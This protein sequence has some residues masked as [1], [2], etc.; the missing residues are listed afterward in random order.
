MNSQFYY[1]RLFKKNK[2][3]AQK[4]M[5]KCSSSHNQ[6]K[7]ILEHINMFFNI[8]MVKL[9][10]LKSHCWEQSGRQTPS[11]KVGGRS[12]QQNR[13]VEILGKTHKNVKDVF[14][15]PSN[16]I[17]KNMNLNIHSLC[18]LLVSIFFVQGSILGARMLGRCSPVRLCVA[19][20]L[21]PA[22]LFCHVILHA[23]LLERV[24]F[25]F[26]RVSF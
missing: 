4:Q 19:C 21:Q 6:T 15:W 24:T 12:K 11:H 7:R 1:P 10:S 14:L 18:K 16:A 23:R 2:E 9:K 17:H 22:R 20:K 13:F 25:S 3:Y 5:K 8:S 26:S